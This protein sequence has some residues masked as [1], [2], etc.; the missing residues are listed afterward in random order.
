MYQK[1]GDQVTLDMENA[2]KQDKEY[3]RLFRLCNSFVKWLE[4]D[5]PEIKVR[6]NHYYSS[7]KKH[8]PSR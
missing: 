7:I 4:K 5:H 8:T 2:I 6:R 1:D 3:D